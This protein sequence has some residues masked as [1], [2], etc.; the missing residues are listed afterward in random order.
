MRDVGQL[1]AKKRRNSPEI[2]QLEAEVGKTQPTSPLRPPLYL[3]ATTQKPQRRCRSPNDQHLLI[4]G[5]A[6]PQ[7]QCPGT[8]PDQAPPLPMRDCHDLTQELGLRRECC[9]PHI[10]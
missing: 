7:G 9:A 2:G 4:Q 6:S 8:P 3:L 5:A 10:I 1:D